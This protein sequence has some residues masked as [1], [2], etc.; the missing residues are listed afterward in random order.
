[1]DLGVDFLAQD[2][3]GAGDG[4]GGDLLAQ[5]LLGA[6]GGDGGFTF[7]GLAGLR[8]DVRRFL[9]GFLDQLSALLLGTGTQLGGGFTT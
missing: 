8:D 4:E 7:G 5:G 1:M 6:L 9:A 3:L 2:A